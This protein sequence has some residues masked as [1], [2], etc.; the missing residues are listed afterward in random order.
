MIVGDLFILFCCL[1]IVGAFF[2]PHDV[3]VALISIPSWLKKHDSFSGSLIG[4]IVSG[5]ATL[6]AGRWAFRVS[7]KTTG[8]EL[9]KE[10]LKAVSKVIEERRSI[11]MAL[12]AFEAEKL[13]GDLNFWKIYEGFF[14][15]KR[16]LNQAKKVCEFFAKKFPNAKEINN[17]I[18]EQGFFY[19]LPN[20]ERECFSNL[21]FLLAKTRSIFLEISLEHPFLREESDE[22]KTEYL[23]NSILS[24]HIGTKIINATENYKYVYEKFMNLSDFY[25][26]QLN[27]I[28]GIFIKPELS[29]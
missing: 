24:S 27:E 10:R 22:K 20:P 25:Q 1:T 19:S 3:F 18:C 6:C 23:I 7:Q 17:N 28:D 15:G 8:R 14:A 2:V 11:E 29:Q 4:A 9:L 5:G 16:D 26:K 21:M 13:I 12:N